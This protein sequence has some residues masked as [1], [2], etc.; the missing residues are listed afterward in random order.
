MKALIGTLAVLSL[1]GCTVERTVVQEATTTTTEA[2]SLVSPPPALPGGDERGYLTYIKTQF[3]PVGADDQLLLDTGWSVCSQFADGADLY[4]ME[5]RVYESSSDY[6][7]AEL[8]SIVVV[9][10]ILFLCPEFAYLL[11]TYV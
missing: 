2:P 11:D 5:Q 1:A 6:N 9:S 4:D 3:G 7:S 8:L 10:S